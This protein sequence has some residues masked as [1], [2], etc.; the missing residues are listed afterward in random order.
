MATHDHDHAHAAHP[1]GHA[2]A[3]GAPDH[4]AHDHGHH[5]EPPYDEV[6]LEAEI[7][8]DREWLFDKFI[9][10]TAWNIALIALILIILAGTQT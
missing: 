6:K 5:A 8:S 2:H 3:H 4:D 9:S 7:L 1:H 10:L